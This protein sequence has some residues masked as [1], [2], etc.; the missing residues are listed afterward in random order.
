MGD[1]AVHRRFDP[2]TGEWVLVSPHRGRRPWQGQVDEPAPARAP[3]AADCYL[4]PGNAR[5]GAVHNPPYEDIF[6]FDNDFPALL[7]DA[8]APSARAGLLHSAPVS[9]TCRVVCFSPRHDLTLAELPAA[10]RRRV[11][12]VWVEQIAELGERWAWVQCFENKGSMM[13]CSSPHPHGQVWALDAVPTL[14]AREAE[15]QRAY[16][17]QHGRALLGDVLGG[18]LEVRE[19]IVVENAHWVVRVPFWARWPFETLLLPRRRVACLTDT[20]EA[21]R[22]ALAAIL[23]TW[24][25][26]QDNLFRCEF[27]YSFGWHGVPPRADAALRDAWV[28]HAHCY[29][30]LLRSAMVRKFMVGFEMLAEAQRDLTPEAAAARMRDAV[31]PHWRTS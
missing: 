11:V 7:D 30:P 1:D 14:V 29:P 10:A 21:E 15:R 28:L 3:F 8:P 27:P 13:G 6:V 5:A 2:L 16:H 26:A 19:R 18:E 25:G 9:G 4:C 12:D 23:G 22:D 31:G 24:L 17:G 20:T